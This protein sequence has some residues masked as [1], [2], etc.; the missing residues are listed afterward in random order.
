MIDEPDN[1]QLKIHS[2]KI[3]CPPRGRKPFLSPTQLEMFS[4]CGEQYRRRYIEHEII[5]PGIAM[6]KGKG[7]HA[8]AEHNMRQKLET[9]VDLSVAE[10]VDVAVT[11]FEAET[12]GGI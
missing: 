11:S 7:F 9:G 1:P 12:S 5:P 10:I 4:R 3:E 2:A 6:A 8:G